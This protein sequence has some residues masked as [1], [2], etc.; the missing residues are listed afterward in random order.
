MDHPKEDHNERELLEYR[1]NRT[2]CKSPLRQEKHPYKR[3][4]IKYN[5]TKTGTSENILWNNSRIQ[6]WSTSKD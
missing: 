1:T 2:Y 5:S 3:F 6:L 4:T